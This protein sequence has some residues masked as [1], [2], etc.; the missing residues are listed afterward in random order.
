[1]KVSLLPVLLL[2]ETMQ[3]KY[4]LKTAGFTGGISQRKSPKEKTIKDEEHMMHSYA[5]FVFLSADRCKILNNMV[6]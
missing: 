1:M 2:R 4:L 6:G 5:L 3:M